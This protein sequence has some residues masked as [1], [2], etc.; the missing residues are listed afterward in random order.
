[1]CA[2]TGRR[3]D[4]EVVVVEPRAVVAE[5]FAGPAQ[6]EHLHRLVED[7]RPLIALDAERLLLVRVGDAESERRQQPTV[8]QTVE[9]RQLLREHH[10]ISAREDHHAH[11]EL[12]LRRA[13]GGERHRDER[14]GSFA[15]EALAEPEAVEA[16]LL[17]RVDDRREAGV[18][19]L[20][21]NAGTRTRSEPSGDR[22]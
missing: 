19:Q 11:P 14:V 20:R 18:V 10:R 21:A 6:P 5:A 17:Q 2:F 22:L 9:R 13:P 3:L 12:Q 16:Q 1:M 8:R 4:A 15:A 7:R